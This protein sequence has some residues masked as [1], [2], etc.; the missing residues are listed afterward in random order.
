MSGGSLAARAH[1]DRV[2]A[3][4]HVVCFRMRVIS[5][6]RG[7]RIDK[8]GITTMTQVQLPGTGV[9]RTH[10]LRPILD[11]SSVNRDRFNDIIPPPRPVAPFPLSCT[12]DLFHFARDP[13]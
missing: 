13:P 4:P 3:R 7:T 11:D 8:A 2:R 5:G 9:T 1:A 12:R 6:E 10:E